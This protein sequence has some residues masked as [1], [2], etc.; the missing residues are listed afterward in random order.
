ME[1]CASTQLETLL[2]Q[3]LKNIATLAQVIISISISMNITIIT[4][5]IRSIT[6]SY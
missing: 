6:T 5:I 1:H 3:I 4:I 2:N